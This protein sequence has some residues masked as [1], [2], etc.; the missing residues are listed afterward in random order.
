VQHAGGEV[1]A[2]GHAGEPVERLDLVEH[3]CVLLNGYGRPGERAAPLPLAGRATTTPVGSTMDFL[4]WWS[5]V[6]GWGSQS[7]KLVVALRL[8]RVPS[9]CPC[10][11]RRDGGGVG[12]AGAAFGQVRVLA[13]DRGPRAGGPALRG[14][15]LAWDAFTGPA[16]GRRVPRHGPGR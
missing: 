6:C 14:R 9:R 4:A 11:H 8:I 7:S 10:A 13:R 12:V 15:R 2:V 3:V 5:V 1:T 16:A